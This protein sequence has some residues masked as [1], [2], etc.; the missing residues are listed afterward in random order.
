MGQV[1]K[2]VHVSTE[3]ITGGAARA[4]YRLHTALNRLGHDSLMFVANRRSKD[5]L[6]TAFDASMDWTSQV[7]RRFR[8]E[9]IARDFARYSTSRPDGFEIFSDDRS[10]YGDNL[11]THLPP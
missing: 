1:M 3:D 5:P 9:R 8:R 7:R 4:A 11:V 6:V 10:E 2:I